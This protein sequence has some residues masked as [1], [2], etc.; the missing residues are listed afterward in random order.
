MN[1]DLHSQSEG[2]FD[3]GVSH[4]SRLILRREH[5]PQSPQ[6]RRLLALV[7]AMSMAVTL[8]MVLILAMVLDLVLVLVLS[9]SPC[10]LLRG[11][12]LHIMELEDGM[13]LGLEL[14]WSGG[15]S[16]DELREDF[17]VDVQEI[18]VAILVAGP[19]GHSG[20]GKAEVWRR[21]Y[22]FTSL[23]TRSVVIEPALRDR[24]RSTM[25]MCFLLHRSVQVAG[26]A[27]EEVRQRLRLALTAGLIR[28][29]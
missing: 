6:K 25:C 4:G 15:G 9:V 23:S 14:G 27:A 13:G 12:V 2:G 7:Q 17:L 24:L 3:I 10:R 8:I 5:F 11:F 1:S 26:C 21:N 22:K 19:N 28:L 18:G 20:R 16:T 29:P